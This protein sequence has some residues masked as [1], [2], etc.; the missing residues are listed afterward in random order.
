M[1]VLDLMNSNIHRSY[2][3]RNR[4]HNLKYF[5]TFPIKI[6]NQSIILLILNFKD[7]KFLLHTNLHK[8]RQVVHLFF[9]QKLRNI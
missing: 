7:I 9:C 4:F 8:N 5:I 3:N 6:L 1:K 2:N